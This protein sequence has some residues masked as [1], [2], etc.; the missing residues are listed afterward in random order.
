MDKTNSTPLQTTHDPSAGDAATS[1]SRPLVTFMLIAYNQERYI[2]EAVEG[3]F[4]QTYS[5]LEI[6]LSDDCSTD[7]T[8]EIMKEMAEQ[9]KGPH[10]I[11]LNRNER[12]LGICG[13]VNRCV[14][15]T[16]GELIVCAAGDDISLP[17]RTEYCA[18]LMFREPRAS[19][20]FSN[21]VLVDENGA[22]ISENLLYPETVSDQIIRIK[23]HKY[24]PV[25]L[26]V[27]NDIK[28]VDCINNWIFGCTACY[29]RELFKIFGELN[30]SLQNEDNVMAFRASLVGK[31]GFINT[32]TVLYRRHRNTLSNLITQTT[33]QKR[34]ENDRENILQKYKDCMVMINHRIDNKAYKILRKKLLARYYETFLDHDGI[35]Y[36]L[37]A[38]PERNILTTGYCL[39]CV[40]HK[41]YLRKL[42]SALKKIKIL[43]CK[44]SEKFIRT[45]KII[46]NLEYQDYD[47][48]LFLYKNIKKRAD[49]ILIGKLNMLEHMKIHGNEYLA[50]SF[51]YKIRNAEIRGCSG[52]IILN[53]NKILYYKQWY[54]KYIFD[55][56]SLWA[57][58]K[59]KIEKLGGVWLCL[60]QRWGKEY[61]HWIHD[62]MPMLYLIKDKVK[63]DGIILNHDLL[64]YQIRS[65]EMLGIE[66]KIYHYNGSYR[67]EVE[68]LIITTPVGSTFFTDGKLL[69]N[70][71]MCIKSKAK[72]HTPYKAKILYISRNDANTRRVLNEYK[73]RRI[74]EANNIEVHMLSNY[75]LDEQMMLFSNA[76]VVIAP[77]GAGIINIIFS[78]RIK[79]LIEIDEEKSDRKMYEALAFDLD[80]RYYKV[81][82]RAVNKKNYQLDYLIDDYN[83][84]QIL[85]IVRKYK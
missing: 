39:T 21:A 84:E 54:K 40:L 59:T 29:K 6:I 3:A 27:I 76:E 12:N 4:A 33:K 60:L 28:N 37:V 68:S 41:Y 48:K 72:N 11:I 47:W 38:K 46:D 9:Y 22:I 17:F 56:N 51:A 79:C 66:E 42:K 32:N 43:L 26:V 5:P 45:W 35:R 81:C 63:Y 44:Y 49:D 67:L 1:T 65:L 62:V 7:R 10:K 2:R 53:K 18:D 55:D 34:I 36:L 23:I 64:P 15:L 73:Y 75:S 8:F 25:T 50:D 78:D 80:I 74:L 71:A 57:L 77:H 24:L 82:A 30:N 31:I 83:I 14:E 85:D 52:L 19:C 16:H 61:Y 58:N 20:V 13:H 69:K 70:M